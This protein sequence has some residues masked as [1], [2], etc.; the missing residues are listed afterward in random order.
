MTEHDIQCQ[1]IR[2][3]DITYRKTIA[4]RL[5][6]IPNGGHRHIAVARKLKAEG[7]RAGFPDL[8]LPIPSGSNHG[9]FIEMKTQ[10]GKPTESQNDWLSFLDSQ[11]YA[12]AVCHSFDDAKRVIEGYLNA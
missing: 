2:W 8:F 11:C 7:V 1:V 3:F 6:A 5:V 4:G 9:L 10:K 12:V